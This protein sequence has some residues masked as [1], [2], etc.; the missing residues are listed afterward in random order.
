M[1]DKKRQIVEETETD[2]CPICQETIDENGV[3]TPCGHEFHEQCLAQWEVGHNT[4]PLCRTILDQK[5]QRIL[6]AQQAQQ[7]EDSDYSDTDEENEDYEEQNFERGIEIARENGFEQPELFAILNEIKTDQ[8]LIDIARERRVT[9]GM[10]DE[11]R[12]YISNLM[13]AL[14]E[15]TGINERTAETNYDWD[16]SELLQHSIANINKIEDM[17]AEGQIGG[18]RKN[19]MKNKNTS[20]K[21]YKNRRN[22]SSN[23]KSMKLRLKKRNTRKKRK[24]QSI[25]GRNRSTK[26]NKV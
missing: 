16:R 24:T 6:E 4:C 12:E 11:T 7:E 9:I 19:K 8:E 13:A 3:V 26:R 21:R 25:R 23:K 17:F 2:E 1:S 15:V 18:F 10:L 5:R 22:A 14:N 20:V